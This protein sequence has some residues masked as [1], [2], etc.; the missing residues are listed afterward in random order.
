MNWASFINGL[1]EVLI[2]LFKRG[3]QYDPPVDLPVTP[4][5]M[6]PIP[7]QPPK[8]LLNEFCLAI[9]SREGYY[10]PGLLKGYPNGTPA[11]QNKNP[12]NLR[13]APGNKMNWNYLAT[14]ENNGFCTFTNYDVGLLALK[15]V[16]TKA[17]EGKSLVYKPTDTIEQFFAKYSPSSDHNDP[18]SYAQEVGGKLGV[19]YKTFQIQQLLA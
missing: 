19:D 7:P 1:T 10:G 9:Q 4:E 15:N 16:V 5:P 12:G 13:C 3:P 18:E 6:E 14:G 11:Y 17:A 2:E 8:N